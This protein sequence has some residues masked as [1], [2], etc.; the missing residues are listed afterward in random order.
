MDNILSEHNTDRQELKVKE[1]TIP[2][3]EVK[4]HNMP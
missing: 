1:K 3:G 4:V 2:Y